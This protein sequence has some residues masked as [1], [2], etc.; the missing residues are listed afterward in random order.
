MADD[1]LIRR[2]DAIRQADRWIRGF[3]EADTI[4]KAIAALPVTPQVRHSQGVKPEVREVIAAICA[5]DDP[6]IGIGQSAYDKADRILAATPATVDALVK[7]LKW[8]EEH[9]AVSNRNNIQRVA[10]DALAAIREARND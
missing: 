8:I 7:A 2:G 6:F 1:D 5:E 9:A 3:V 4:G 10:Q